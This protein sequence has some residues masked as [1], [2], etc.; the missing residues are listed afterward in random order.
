M[1]ITF[2]IKKPEDKPFTPAEQ[3]AIESQC[4]MMQSDL[5]NCIVGEYKAHYKIEK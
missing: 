4:E 3:M 1:K 2:I 5:E